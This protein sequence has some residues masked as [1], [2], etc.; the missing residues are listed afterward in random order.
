MTT[1]SIVV[2]AHD[3]GAH[4]A[5]CLTSLLAQDRPAEIIVV[6]DGSHDDTAAIAD[7]FA[8]V[9][10]LRQDHR[11]AATARNRGA[12]AASGKILVFVD[13]DMRFPPGWVSAMVAPFA[14]PKRTVTVV[15][16]RP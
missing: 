15:P 5:E 14:D 8:A 11:G 3:E 16:R 6:D 13:G 9:T 1:V 7:G 12:A 4:I 2:A 10:V